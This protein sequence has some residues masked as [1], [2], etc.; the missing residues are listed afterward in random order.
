[1][2]VK[3]REVLSRAD[4]VV[5]DHLVAPRI[6]DWA[7][8]GAKRIYVGKEAGRHTLSQD[9]INRL[10]IREARSGKTVVRLKGG[11]PMLFGRGGEEALAL[12]KAR[13][14]YD[15]VPGVTSAIAVPAYAG[16][17]V[18]HRGL[19]S[20]LAVITGHEDPSKSGSVL[21]WKE[22]ATACDT[23]VCLMGVATLPGMVQELVRHGRP[24]ST[25]C[26]VI[27]WGTRSRQRTVSGTLRTI[28]QR[29]AKAGVRP[30]AVTV[31]GDVVRLRPRLNWFERLPLIGR[32]IVVTR[33]AEK[34]S[35]FAQQLE[36]LG[37]E[38]DVLPAIELAPVKANGALRRALS[39]I[40][41]TD[42]VFFTSP[43]GIAW[44]SRLLKPER[45]DVRCLAEC[46]IAAIGPKTA[47]AVEAAGLH[48]D[49]VPKRFSQEG[50]LADFPQRVLAGR[51]ALVLSAEA[52]RDVLTEGLRRRG[53]RVRK[54]P[55]YRTLVPKALD[56]RVREVFHEAPDYVTVTSA[57]CVEHLHDALRAAGLGARFARLR[58][59]SIG[60]VTSAAVRAH[61]GR[62]AVEART[63]TLE[64]LTEAM[65]RTAGARR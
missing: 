26:A 10:L 56:A 30:P 9:A 44:F 48:V 25:P 55:I 42:W 35:E 5:Y 19:S 24:G 34:A 62:V 47:A 22:L 58:F 18:T 38:V 54:V 15:V 60:P 11:D 27:E 7:P 17:P 23:V 49:Y 50:L 6:L 51:E 31:V 29:V 8:A 45:R 2:T 65:T 52:S 16:I 14:R 53:M 39:R 61:G 46:R 43:E 64:G 12:A 40:P 37:A 33:A 21:R 20:S 59:A 57:S 3:G 13:V 4:V 41:R 28:V 1:M 63:A 36:A 32:R